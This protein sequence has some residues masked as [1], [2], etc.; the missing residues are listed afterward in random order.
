MDKTEID[1]IGEALEEASLDILDVNGRLEPVYSE[2]YDLIEGVKEILKVSKEIQ[3]S[4][5]DRI[6]FIKKNK[7]GTRQYVG[8]TELGGRIFKALGMD[9]SSALRN[10]NDFKFH[11][12]IS[13]FINES[14]DKDVKKFLLLVKSAT[15]LE[16]MNL[17]DLFNGF[18]KSIKEKVNSEYFKKNIAN[19]ERNSIENFRNYNSYIAAQF[20]RRSR[21]L[22]LRIDLGYIESHVEAN[23][24]D[25]KKIYLNLKND[26]HKLHVDL[27]RKIL[28]N[29]F[30][31]FVWKIEYG[32]KKTFHIHV[33]LI[34][35]SSNLRSDV[36]INK[37]IGDHWNRVVTKNNGYY[38]NCNAK[39]NGYRFCGI[40]QVHRDDVEM[41]RHL[42][43][44]IGTYLTKP[45]YVLCLKT[46]DGGRSFGK[47]NM[48]K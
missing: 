22:F 36:A 27:T 31:G 2:D 35:N 21:L 18:F 39:K 9:M 30:L 45:D 38:F 24:H 32:I 42:R 47:G 15:G 14:K 7:K 13:I 4:S 43:E 16:A 25:L 8:M 44:R 33:L 3:I 34:I 20:A 41:R 1:M 37:I 11:P 6:F 28:K 23:K 26:W 48:P 17:I 12:L 5:D 10:F 46:P 40:G 29:N 19:F